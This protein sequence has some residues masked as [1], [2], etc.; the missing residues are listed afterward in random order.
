MVNVGLSF[1]CGS[2]NSNLQCCLIEVKND[3]KPAPLGPLGSRRTSAQSVAN[4][5]QPSGLE[6]LA[7]AAKEEE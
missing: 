6:S 4:S 5:D 3:I 7:E 1:E 2:I